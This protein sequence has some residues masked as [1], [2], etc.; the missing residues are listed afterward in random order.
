[1]NEDL[2]INLV[3][4]LRRH[5]PRLGTRKLYR[6]LSN[7][8]KNLPFSIG[9]DK[10]FLIL[11]KYGHLVIKKRAFIKTT[12]SRHSYQTHRNLVKGLTINRPNQVWVADITY[13]RTEKGFVYL[14]LLTD[15]Y[16]RKIVGFDLLRK[17][18]VKGTLNAF[19][20]ARKN[21]TTL[22]HLIH[23]SDRGAQYAC[24]EYCNHLNNAGVSMSMTQED[25][26]YE[27]AVAERVN[28]ILKDEFYLDRRFPTYEAALVAVSD[29]IHI[30]NSMRPHMSLN[31]LTPSQKYA[32]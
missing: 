7:D 27:N 24:R 22:S 1:M 9:R 14:Y 18:T 6:L 4:D 28:G 20:M 13:I 8:L 11:R 30:Y 5:M 21:T 29:A 2:V 31:N 3:Q 19:N 26:V 16:S 23:H 10:L 32:A 25:H 12:Y 17:L 15:L